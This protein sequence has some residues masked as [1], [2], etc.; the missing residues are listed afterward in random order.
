VRPSVFDIYAAAERFRVF[1]AT[2]QVSAPN[3]NGVVNSHFRERMMVERAFTA[4]TPGPPWLVSIEGCHTIG[5]LLMHIV[6]LKERMLM[7]E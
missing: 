5:F 4:F 7:L 3:A 2:V 6:L 1:V